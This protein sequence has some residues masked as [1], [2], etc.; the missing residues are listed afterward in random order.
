MVANKRNIRARSPSF[1]V[2]AYDYSLNSDL[3][4]DKSLDLYG[5]TVTSDCFAYKNDLYLGVGHASR[6][7]QVAYDAD[8]AHS[9]FNTS[10]GMIMNHQGQVVA[11]TALSAGPWTQEID[12]RFTQFLDF[13]RVHCMYG[14]SRVVADS[15]SEVLTGSIDPGAGEYASAGVVTG[16][17]TKFLTELS[18]GDL[19]TVSGETRR[20]AA[21]GDD[22]NIIVSPAFSDN[23][24]DTSPEKYVATK[25]RFG[26]S[27]YNGVNTNSDGNDITAMDA[28]IGIMD[29]SPV[30]YLPSVQADG[31]LKIASGIL[32]DYS[33]DYFK[34]ANFFHHPEIHSGDLSTGSALTGT[35]N[36]KAIYE[37]IDHA[38]KVQSSA[39]SVE[40][41]TGT[42][43]AK[44]VVLQ[45]Y[46]LQLT[47]KRD[48]SSL[49]NPQGYTA[50]NWGARSEVKIVLYRTTDE[51]SVYH[52]CAEALMDYS[53][54]FQQ[55][56]DTLPDSELEDNDS[57]Y[58]NG[59]NFSHVAPPSLYD[60]AVWK[61]RV[62]LATTEN[63]VWFS[64]RFAENTEAGFSDS[65]VRAV[66]NRSEKIRALCPNL[67]HLLI[68][69]ARNGY[70]MSGEG[71]SPSGAGPGFS[72]L[73]VFA[74]GQ[75]AIDG[76]CRVETPLGV[77]FQTSQGLM[78]CGR[79][80][81]V[82]HQGAKIEDQ[83]TGTN[84]A[85]DA[86][87]FGKEHEVRFTVAGGQKI[88]VYN[89]LF[90][91]WSTWELHNDT[92]ANAGSVVVDNIHY[93]L[94]TR[95]LLYKQQADETYFDNID[96][97][98]GVGDSEDN[99]PYSLQL[100]SG[101]INIGQLQQVG[102]VYRLLM[103]GDFNTTSLPHF[104]IY[105]DYSTSGTQIAYPSTGP[106]TSKFQLE[107]KLP[108][109]KVKSFK[110][111]LSESEPAAGG[112]YMAIQSISMLVGIKRPETSFKLPS[113][114]RLTVT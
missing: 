39:P 94:N 8:T 60:I 34:E 41:N 56:T 44:D 3:L 83:I 45:I 80:M 29:F 101:W 48:A 86:H 73:R 55:I 110:F 114:D 89:F 65:S 61:N 50:V 54:V 52:R 113:A 51:G 25:F 106:G 79:N 64:N 78:L 32:W 12:F 92:G 17:G 21:L 82:A 20:V 11:K 85:I 95:G 111:T 68:L 6:P 112:G 59:G 40:W 26:S 58:T 57:L 81:Q 100:T 67:E 96:S 71:S 97:S 1:L 49:A 72:P 47:Y 22:T 16:V 62:I 93:R 88:A 33:G 37:W 9:V 7:S 38:G 46:T 28:A 66:D 107:L 53:G 74:P 76:T 90:D 69:G 5:I 18:V 91:Q 36:Y 75:G 4:T 84:Y 30:R 108:K 103:L 43:A 31:A 63:T 2:N 10:V 15:S 35:F 77:F 23:D 98:P 27:R 19:I 105:T 102:R 24:N 42:I 104:V 70:Y 87:V 14:V 13:N 109:Q 99:R